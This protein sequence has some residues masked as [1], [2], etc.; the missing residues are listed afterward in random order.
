MSIYLNKIRQKKR[1]FERRKV[2][3]AGS[4]IIKS[5]DKNFKYS[6]GGINRAEETF[7]FTS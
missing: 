1:R 2:E 4:K 6:F 5:V 3:F 7:R